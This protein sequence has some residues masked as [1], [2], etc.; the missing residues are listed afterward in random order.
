M[1]DVSDN[2]EFV[3]IEDLKEKFLKLQDKLIKM[4][5]DIKDFVNRLHDIPNW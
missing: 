3:T 2:E 5:E 4:E 1:I